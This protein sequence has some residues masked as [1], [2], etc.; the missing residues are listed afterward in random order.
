MECVDCCEFQKFDGK[1]F[2]CSLYESKL[3]C[4]K[5]NGNVSV[6]RCKDC[7]EETVEYTLR[8]KNEFDRVAKNKENGE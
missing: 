1:K 8:S 6:I 7:I 2:R 4:Y 5:E 3:K